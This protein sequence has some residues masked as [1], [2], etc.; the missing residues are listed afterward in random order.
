M[1]TE[2]FSWWGLQTGWRSQ[3]SKGYDVTA[4]L[5]GVD[6][7]YQARSVNEVEDLFSKACRRTFLRR[8][9]RWMRPPPDRSP[10]NQGDLTE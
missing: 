1:A 8:Y 7:W 4:T 10:G 6:I 3:R 5:D 2:L 9:F